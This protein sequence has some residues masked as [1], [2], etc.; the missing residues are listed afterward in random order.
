MNERVGF[1]GGSDL[2][3]ILSDDWEDLWEVKVGLK[4]PKDLS[5]VLPVQMGIVTEDLNIL[6]FSKSTGKGVVGKQRQ[7]KVNLLSVPFKGTVDGC[8]E[9]ENCIL[10]AK[11]TNAN[12]S[13]TK[14]MQYYKPQM[15]LY[16]GLSQ[17]KGCYLS[18]IF[19][20]N[21]WESDFMCFDED[22]FNKLVGIT[23]TFWG[24]VTSNTRPVFT[25]L[26]TK[27]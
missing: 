7:F 6:W 18:V 24:Y 2:N 10:E 11:H 26:S 17:S 22:Y 5:N 20:N 13:M 8:I 9:G 23:S 1:I 19:G 16:C 3:Q 25:N 15:Q 21:R 12:N 14:V 27:I 4:K